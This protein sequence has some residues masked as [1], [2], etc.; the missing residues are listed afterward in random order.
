M[1]FRDLIV[2]LGYLWL[3]WRILFESNSLKL[4][5]KLFFFTSVSNYCE[6]RKKSV[7]LKIN[8]NI[9][10]ST[11][12]G[13]NFLET[14][15]HSREQVFSILR[16]QSGQPYPVSSGFSRPH[17]ALRRKRNHCEQP[18]AFPS[19]MRVH[20]TSLSLVLQETSAKQQL[21]TYFTIFCSFL[22]V[23]IRLGRKKNAHFCFF[24][25][26]KVNKQGEILFSFKSGYYGP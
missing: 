14:F 13:G 25:M 1:L 11:N 15:W 6:K 2:S 23:F 7:F 12:L 20:V 16:A 10:I 9:K 8:F 3:D 5:F 22:S 4:C 21:C 18:F 17:A 19:G 26:E 24:F